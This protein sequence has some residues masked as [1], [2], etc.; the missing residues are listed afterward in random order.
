MDLGPVTSTLTTA[1]Q[2]TLAT[3]EAVIKY[4]I[5]SFIEVGNALSRIR[6]GRLYRDHYQTFEGYCKSRWDLS[7]RHVNRLIA[8][9]E[10]A[11]DVG[12][13]GPIPAS[14]SVVRPLVS[15]PK[16]ERAE[17]WQDAV[18]SAPKDAAGKPKVTAKH[19]EQAIAKHDKTAPDMKAE[20]YTC[21]NCGG[22]DQAT[23]DEGSYCKTCQDPVD[24]PTESQAEINTRLLRELKEAIQSAQAIAKK[25]VTNKDVIDQ[26]I[27]RR[28][29]GRG[30]GR[31]S[32]NVTRWLGLSKERR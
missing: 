12:P 21:P 15:V 22:H 14:E 27:F 23:D 2:K 31:A 16:E 30:L 3:Y 32:R 1:E 20:S 5:E 17:V 24:A 26:Q 18:E 28:D 9:G 4:G 7:S 19:V 13:I 10:V 29:I 6:E 8:A 11:E 25:L